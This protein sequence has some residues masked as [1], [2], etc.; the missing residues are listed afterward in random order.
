VADG[1]IVVGHRG[2]TL[3]WLPMNRIVRPVVSLALL[4]HTVGCAGENKLRNATHTAS[5]A[6]PAGIQMTETGLRGSLLLIGGSLDADDKAVYERFVQLARSA[7]GNS[8]PRF[9]MVTAASGDQDE[10]VRRQITALQTYCDDAFVDIARRETSS[11][12]TLALIDA[13][14]G[15]LFT[16]GD[17]KRITDRYLADGRDKPEA[18]AMRRLLQRGG[19]I[20]GNSAGDAMM[21]DPM[22]LSGRSGAALG[23]R[24]AS[25]RRPVAS[26][27][28]SAASGASGESDDRPERA[29]PSLG[30]QIGKGMGFLPW[31]IADSHFFERERFGRL[32]AALEASGR[33]LGLGVDAGACIEIDLATGEAI[34]LTDAESLLVDIGAIQRDVLVRRNI[35]TQLIEQGMRVSLADRSRDPVCAASAEPSRIEDVAVEAGGRNRRDA[36][37]RFFRAAQTCRGTAIRLRLDGYQQIGWSAGPGAVVEIRPD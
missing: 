37:R 19:V 6:P 11:E 18:R 36:S 32:V 3:H 9:V 5:T 13:A 35:R 10:A 7:A 8:R 17:Q 25:A 14:H 34:G 2:P 31:A 1:E 26:E 4:L 15:L 23:I 33:R 12:Q 16:G 28:Q 29:D 24:A 22:F 30:P 20:A 27:A 21:S